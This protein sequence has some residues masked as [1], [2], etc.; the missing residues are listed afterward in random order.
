MTNSVGCIVYKPVQTSPIK[1]KG[2]AFGK[3]LPTAEEAIAYFEAKLAK[4]TALVAE[5][6][7]KVDTLIPNMAFR[8]YLPTGVSVYYEMVL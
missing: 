5:Q 2:K 6:G 3:Q 7:G 4:W 1:L 8:A